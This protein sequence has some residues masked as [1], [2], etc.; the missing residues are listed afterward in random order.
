M[1]R[2]VFEMHVPVS[3]NLI[4]RFFL[5]AGREALFPGLLTVHF[6]IACSMQKQRGRP[7]PFYHVNDVYLGR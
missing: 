7:G 6:L 4:A 2:Q 1:R 5:S 3:Y